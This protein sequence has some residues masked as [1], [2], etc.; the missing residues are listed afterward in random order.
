[1]SD[2]IIKAINVRI[3]WTHQ[4]IL[5]L[6]GQL[7]QAQFS[8]QPGPTSPP[9]GWHVWHAARWADR[10]QASFKMEDLADSF[11]GPLAHEIWKSDNIE[12]VWGLDGDRLG[13]LETGA[14]MDID[15][16]VEV[17]ELDQALHLEYARRAMAVAEKAFSEL[18]PDLLTETRPSILPQLKTSR[19]APPEF[20]GD[21]EVIVFDELL[22]HAT[23]IGRHLGVMEALKGAL[24]GLAG[25]VSV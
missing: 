22:F 23:H 20:V 13:L 14:T 17:A 3:E 19:D 15:A 12:V 10:M 21:R 24:F 11:K 25:S 16:A 2:P 8:K 4:N 9:I 18:K 5:E 7:S 1:M 6:A